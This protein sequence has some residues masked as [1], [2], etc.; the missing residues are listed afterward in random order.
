MRN[1]MDPPD[2]YS[3]E[4]KLTLEEKGAQDSWFSTHMINMAAATHEPSVQVDIRNA[5]EE[6]CAQHGQECWK[7]D[8]RSIL[9][10]RKQ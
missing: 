9:T 5:I 1:W 2:S 10:L 7:P 3:D 8:A 4:E 6:E